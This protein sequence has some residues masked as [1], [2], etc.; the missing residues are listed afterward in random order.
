MRTDLI[1]TAWTQAVFPGRSLLSWHGKNRHPSHSEEDGG[2][3]CSKVCSPCGNQHILH[4]QELENENLF[5]HSRTE[6]C[7][8]R[9]KRKVNGI[10]LILN[11]CLPL[12]NDKVRSPFLPSASTITQQSCRVSTSGSISL[13]SKL[14]E[15]SHLSCLYHHNHTFSLQRE[16]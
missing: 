9:S 6:I 15:N 3:M 14:H 1:Q 7:L 13:A 12:C 11:L 4:R 16:S 5:H 10:I 2:N 8:K